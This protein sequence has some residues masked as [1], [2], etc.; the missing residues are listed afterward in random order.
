MQKVAFHRNAWLLPPV[1]LIA[2]QRMLEPGKM[3]ANL[4]CAPSLGIRFDQAEIGLP[5]ELPYTVACYRRSACVHDSH[6][7]PIGSAAPNRRV[8]DA[9][10]RLD[11]TIDQCQ[12]HLFDGARFEL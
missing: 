10:T 5:V 3:H 8:D 9:F 1:R 6:L 4:M 2:Y 7:L 11:N 12:I